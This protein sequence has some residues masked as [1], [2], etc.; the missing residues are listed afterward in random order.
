MRQVENFNVETLTV[1]ANFTDS[2]IAVMKGFL[3]DAISYMNGLGKSL[4]KKKI[5]VDFFKYCL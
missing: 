5:F 3:Q 1:S 4:R 2:A